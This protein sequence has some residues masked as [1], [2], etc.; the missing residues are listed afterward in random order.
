[1]ITCA[2]CHNTNNLDDAEFC[3]NCGF[4]LNSNYCTNEYCDRNNGSSVPLPENACYCDCCG[5]ESEYYRLGLVSPEN[6]N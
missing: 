6:F 2:K 1:M 5:N 4:E 3:T